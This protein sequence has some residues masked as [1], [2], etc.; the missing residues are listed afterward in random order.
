MKWGY[1]IEVNLPPLPPLPL[2]AFPSFNS[3]GYG[4]K[5]HGWCG[6]DKVGV[7]I[8]GEQVLG[9]VWVVGLG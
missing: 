7:R 8:R 1:G 4:D 3:M 5:V 6:G 2:Y 9:V